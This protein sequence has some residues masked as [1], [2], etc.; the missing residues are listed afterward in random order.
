MESLNGAWRLTLWGRNIGNTYYW[1]AVNRDLDTTVRFT[2]MPR[3]YGATLNY[4]FK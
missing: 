4:R 2:G 3:T 1:T